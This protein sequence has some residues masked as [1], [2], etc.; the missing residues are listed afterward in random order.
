MKKY[1]NRSKCFNSSIAVN[2]FELTIKHHIH[3]SSTEIAI[4][5]I[6]FWGHA[7][8]TRL[9]KSHYVKPLITG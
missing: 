5:A 2:E 3:V 7:F 6:N 8:I 9:N 4:E 1:I